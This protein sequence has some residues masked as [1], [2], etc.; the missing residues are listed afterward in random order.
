[1]TSASRQLLEQL[2]GYELL[3]AAVAQADYGVPL[4]G[5]GQQFHLEVTRREHGGVQVVVAPVKRHRCQGNHSTRA[6][7]GFLQKILKPALPSVTV[8][9]G[10]QKGPTTPFTFHC[11]GHTQLSLENKLAPSFLVFPYKII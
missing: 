11:V 1:L 3:G 10:H 8:H 5:R 9:R 4:I 6:W 7:R 2:E